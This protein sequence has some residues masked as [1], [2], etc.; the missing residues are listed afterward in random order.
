MQFFRRSIGFALALAGFFLL[1]ACDS[2]PT[3][4]SED[5]GYDY[6]PINKDYAEEVVVPTYA[7]LRDKGAELHS[8]VEQFAQ[9]TTNQQLLNK[10]AE[11][12]KEARIP[13]EASEAFLFGP[14][15]F[16]S[17]DPA[18]DSWPVDRQQL[19]DILESDLELDQD[20]V[21]LLGP[22][23]RGFHT[24]EYLLFREGQPRDAADYTA[25]ERDYLVAVSQILADDTHKLWAA[26][27]EDGFATEFAQA[28]QAGSRYYTAQDATMEIA[29]GIIL[30]CDE[31]GNGKIADPSEEND[32]SLV[33]SQFSFNSLTDFRNNMESVRNAYTGAYFSEGDD[34]GLDTFVT[35]Q[36]ADLDSEIKA[37]IQ[38]AIDAI[39][40]IPEPFRENLQAPEV[41]IAIQ[42]INAVADI[43]SSE[44]KPLIESS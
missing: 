14:A 31:V 28:G 21:E 42:K 30:I 9:D 16:M 20:A 43:F 2:S 40:A 44:V 26:W 6:S 18:L 19:E 1:A 13:W 5:E 38:E 41:A 17:L 27:S 8:T 10:A 4:S 22:M 32:V 25:R 36:D 35:E 7:E 37:K 39:N 24:I 34:Q 33:E 23:V 15:A 12:W 11:T 29:D 3:D